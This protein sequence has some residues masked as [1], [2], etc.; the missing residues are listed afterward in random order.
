MKLRTKLTVFS[1]LLL[2]AAITLCCA[3][4]VS[5]AY[6]GEV[7]SITS[8]GLSDYEDLYREF[9]WR[10]VESIPDEPIVRLSLIHI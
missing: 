5:F 3:I 7:E 4:I 6:Q 9:I 10:S 8:L 2:T 1:I